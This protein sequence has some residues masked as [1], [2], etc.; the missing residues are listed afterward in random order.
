MSLSY[1]HHRSHN[2][3]QQQLRTGVKY[4]LQSAISVNCYK[5]ESC[6]ALNGFLR[7]IYIRRDIFTRVSEI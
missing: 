5:L 2:K 7:C 6:L 1:N 4:M 3:Q